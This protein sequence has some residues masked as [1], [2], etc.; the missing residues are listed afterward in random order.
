LKYSTVSPSFTYIKHNDCI[1]FVKQST[2]GTHVYFSMLRSMRIL[3]DFKCMQHR[4]LHYPSD[5][6]RNRIAKHDPACVMVVDAEGA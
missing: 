1:S 6:Q 3:P 2:T 4:P 5:M